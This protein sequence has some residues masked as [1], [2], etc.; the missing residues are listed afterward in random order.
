LSLK[1]KMIRKWKI[2]RTISL[3]IHHRILKHTG[4]AEATKISPLAA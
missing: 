2:K 3:K 1:P 4:R